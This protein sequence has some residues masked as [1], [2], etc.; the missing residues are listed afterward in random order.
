MDRPAGTLP[1]D[2]ARQLRPLMTWVHRYS[3]EP[4]PA[5]GEGG[6]PSYGRAGPRMCLLW[7]GHEDPSSAGPGQPSAR[8][9]P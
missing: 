5:V 4:G 8:L 3:V 1:Q 7:A 6:H 9:C 2:K